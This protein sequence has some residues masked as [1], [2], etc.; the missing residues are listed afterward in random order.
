[1]NDHDAETSCTYIDMM[2]YILHIM[3]CISKCTIHLGCLYEYNFGVQPK[4]RD[5]S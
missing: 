4:R 3:C 5:G 2:L 1:M